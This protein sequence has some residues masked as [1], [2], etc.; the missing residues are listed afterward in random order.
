M[1]CILVG[2]E[3]GI[4]VLPG[5]A[6]LL[7]AVPVQLV[8]GLLTN[9]KQEEMTDVISQRVTLMGGI[10]DAVKI[11]KYNAW[12]L[13]FIKVIHG[14]RQAELHF[15]KYITMYRSINFVISFCTPMIVALACFASFYIY[16][17][18]PIVAVTSFTILSIANSLR[19]PLFL[20]PTSTKAVSG[21]FYCLGCGAA[22]CPVA[23]CVP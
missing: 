1:V 9:K 7:V 21:T 3:T 2:V 5:V 4:W 14:Y 20:L 10:L 23:H 6:V 18:V 16:S 17:G 13:F 12:E 22:W 8:L 15:L 11:V 19:Y